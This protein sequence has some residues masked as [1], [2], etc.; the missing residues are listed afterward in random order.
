MSE[1]ARSLPVLPVGT[2]GRR[3]LGW[4]GMLWAIV[5]E[6]TLF[7]YLL[8]SYGYF[9]VQL[10]GNWMPR[11]VPPLRLALPG[12]VLLV[13]SVPAM[14]LGSF[15][16]RR[17]RTVALLIGLVLALALG[18]AFG[19]LQGLDWRSEPLTLR[20]GEF[21]SVY[22]TLTGLHL[23]HLAAGLLGLLLMLIWSAL[24]YFDARRHA[25]VLILAAYWYFVVVVGVTVFVALYVLPRVW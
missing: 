3:S 1:T 17:G 13:I 15:G 7:A 25:P 14:W 12:I 16:A 19:V 6:G 10:A 11:Q 4:W 18:A 20:Q 24:G 23:A 8:F 22:Y 9:A 21:G 2:P 5:T